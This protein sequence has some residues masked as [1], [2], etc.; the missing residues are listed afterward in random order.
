M[1]RLRTAI[2]LLNN[3]SPRRL[4]MWLATLAAIGAVLVANAL[5]PLG[6]GAGSEWSTL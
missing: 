3:D 4:R 5:M 1:Q 6:M 2:T